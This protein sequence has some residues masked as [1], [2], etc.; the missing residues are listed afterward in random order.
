MSELAPQAPEKHMESLAELAKDL[1]VRPE[2]SEHASPEKQLNVEAVQ[3]AVEQAHEASPIANALERLQAEEAAAAEP[4]PAPVNRELK[5]LTLQRELSHIQRKLP[6]ADR[7]LSK[8][9]HQPAVRLVSDAADKTVT[10]PSGLLGGGVMAF[11]GSVLY[12]YL[13]KHIGF[14]YNYF[15][16]LLLFVSG[17]AFGLLL[18][19]IARSLTRKHA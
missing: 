5:K 1:E 9:I 14:S 18:E 12:L 4:A 6:K 7:A 2:I 19:L 8:V 17:F 15:V 13:A 11:L 10:R 3:T 16:F